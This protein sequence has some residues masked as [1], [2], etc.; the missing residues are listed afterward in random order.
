ML[1]LLMLFQLGWLLERPQHVHVRFKSLC[2]MQQAVHLR[3]Q[4]ALCKLTFRVPLSLLT[5]PIP[6]I[7][8]MIGAFSI[9]PGCSRSCC[10]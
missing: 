6:V 4:S 8:K 10:C 2:S 9:L 5:C 1:H 7:A 3:G